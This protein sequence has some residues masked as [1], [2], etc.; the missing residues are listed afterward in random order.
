MAMFELIEIDDDEVEICRIAAKLMDRVDAN[1]DEAIG[2][3]VFDAQEFFKEH[4]RD[5]SGPLEW[6]KWRAER[7]TWEYEKTLEILGGDFRKH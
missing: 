1:D 2:Q 7:R 4:K 3:F 5:P 6:L